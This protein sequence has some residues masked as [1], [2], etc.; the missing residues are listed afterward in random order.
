MD[1]PLAPLRALFGSET[2]NAKQV[3][4]D[5][6]TAATARGL[7]VTLSAL[8]DCTPEELARQGCVLIVAATTGDGEVTYDA[9]LLWEALEAPD[10]P[11]LDGL[12]FAVLGLGDTA[13]FDFCQAAVDF[14]RRLAELGGRRLHELVT[15]DLDYDDD[16]AR[17]IDAVLDLV[18]PRH[19]SPADPSEG[20][21]ASP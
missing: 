1:A 4:H 6:A 21:P 10:A 12:P 19:V 15:C 2:G 9:L 3:A 17:W 11:R 8:G 20:R 14:D 18:A 5:L 7:D 13:Y 16:A